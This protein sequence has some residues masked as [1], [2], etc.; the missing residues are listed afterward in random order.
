MKVSLAGI[1]AP[2]DSRTKGNLGQSYS[3]C[4]KEYLAELVLNKLVDIKGYGLDRNDYV[5]GVIFLKGIN[6]NI[7]MIRA[8]L[9]EVSGEKLSRDCDLG[10]Y[11]QAQKEAMRS[12]RGIW[13]Q[14]T[15][16]IIK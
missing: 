2:E 3:E 11:R 13:S 14:V 4:A 12:K 8:G 16:G 10:P 1:D 5:L 9:A 6:I 7:E 15:K